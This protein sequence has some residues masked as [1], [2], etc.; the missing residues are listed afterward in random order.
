MDN[1]KKHNIFVNVPLSQNL[2]FYLLQ[3]FE[4]LFTTDSVYIST[5]I[6]CWTNV[7]L[8]YS[9]NPSWNGLVQ[10]LNSP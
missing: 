3:I 10:V 7:C 4:I 5:L 1:V 8:Q 9:R 2:R 6:W